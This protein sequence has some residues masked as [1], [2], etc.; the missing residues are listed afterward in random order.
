MNNYEVLENL[1]LLDNDFLNGVIS[2]R[3]YEM[4]SEILMQQYK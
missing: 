3:E 2:E 4:W 1:E